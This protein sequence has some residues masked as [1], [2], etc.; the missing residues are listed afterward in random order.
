MRSEDQAS[1]DKNFPNTYRPAL[2]ST[3]LSIQWIMGKFL[4][5][6]GR[7]MAIIT[8]PPSNDEVKEYSLLLLLSLFT[9]I[10]TYI[11]TYLLTYLVTYL[12]Q[13]S[14]YSVSAVLTVVQI[15]QIRINIH[16]HSTKI[17]NTVNTSTHIVKTPTHTTAMSRDQCLGPTATYRNI[18]HNKLRTSMFGGNSDISQYIPEQAHNLH[19]WDQQRHIAV[20]SRT[21][22]EPPRLRSTAT[23]CNISQNKLRT[24]TFGTNSDISQYIPEQAQN[25][26]FWDEQRHIVIYPIISSEPQRLGPTATYRNI[27]QN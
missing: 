24:S 5:Y 6:S 14:F 15:K 26:N 9:C 7:D 21:S 18:S 4:G 22:S 17:Q 8:H 3:Q 2:G 10:H 13:L 27:P 1:V 11:L 19:V 12:L 20:Y 25:L 16:K 23:Y